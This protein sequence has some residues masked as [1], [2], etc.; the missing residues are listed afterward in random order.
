M[1]SWNYKVLLFYR[2]ILKSNKHQYW[3]SYSKNDLQIFYCQMKS[4]CL[5]C[6]CFRTTALISRKQIISLQIRLE[7]EEMLNTSSEWNQKSKTFI[8]KYS[9]ICILTIRWCQIKF[10]IYH[11]MPFRWSSNILFTWGEFYLNEYTEFGIFYPKW[12]NLILCKSS[13]D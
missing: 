1:M 7:N 3:V 4:C 9:F 13:M 2:L 6:W 11:T 10:E 5:G 8:W 12:I